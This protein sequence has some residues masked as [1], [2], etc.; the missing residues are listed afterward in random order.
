MASRR[1]GVIVEREGG[2]QGIHRLKERDGTDETTDDCHA[3]HDAPFPDGGERVPCAGARLG[4]LD[5]GL[6]RRL[7]RDRCRVWRFANGRSK[8]APSL[9]VQDPDTRLP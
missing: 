8:S 5:L 3:E 6:V 4:G 1:A 7:C 9:F 2:R